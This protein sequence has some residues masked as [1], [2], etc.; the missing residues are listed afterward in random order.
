M[1][2]APLDLARS[3]IL[4]S[5]DDGI[6]APGLKLLERIARMLSRDVWVVAPE[7]EQSAASHS[8]TIR[9]PLR[10]RKIKS[11]RFAVDGTPTDCVLLAIHHI[12]KDRRPTLCLSGVNRGANLGEDVTYSGTV[13]AAMEATLL[14]VPAIA[15][16]QACKAPSPVRWSTAEHY[17]GG[18][19]RR[20][21]RMTW[22]RNVMI[23]VNFPNV[24]APAVRGV[25]VAGQGRHKIGDQLVENR[26]PRGVPY[27]WIGAMRHED[28]TRAGTDIAAVNDGW[29]SVTPLFLDL[30]HRPTMRRLAK[31]FA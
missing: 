9:H 7:T 26:D 21:T 29:I 27:Y 15:L 19:V 14:G 13:A 10:V 12:L 23:N 22:P 3:R 2:K 1:F 11:R 24:L 4:V 5:N 16:S 20:L 18:I 8:L 17:A 6:A 25:A 30:S 31:L 28:A